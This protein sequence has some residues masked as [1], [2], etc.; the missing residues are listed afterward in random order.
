MTIRPRIIAMVFAA[1]A[2]A[3]CRL[4]PVETTCCSS[5]SESQDDDACP[6]VLGDTLLQRRAVNDE[7]LKELIESE[8]AI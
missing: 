2:L 1:S 5:A 3:L 8:A 7:I 6:E 4:E